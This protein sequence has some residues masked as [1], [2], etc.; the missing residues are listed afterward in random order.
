MGTSL[1]AMF[2][3]RLIVLIV[4]FLLVRRMEE[5]IWV[6]NGGS[7]RA[8]LPSGME[9]WEVI[10]WWKVREENWDEFFTSFEDKTEEELRLAIDHYRANPDWIDWRLAQEERWTEQDALTWN[11]Q[12]RQ[13]WQKSE[14]P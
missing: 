2:R 5:L 8:A 6:S 4:L 10:R 14:Q 1:V 3:Y 7:L 13:L 9:V 11:E 12:V